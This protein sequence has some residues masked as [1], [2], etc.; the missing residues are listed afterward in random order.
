MPALRSISKPT[1]FA[2]WRQTSEL[3]DDQ[4]HVTETRVVDG[5]APGIRHAYGRCRNGFWFF[6]SMT[7]AEELEFWNI[8]L[9]WRTRHKSG[10]HQFIAVSSGKPPNCGTPNTPP[11]VTQIAPPLEDCSATCVCS[12]AA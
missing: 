6:I 3:F 10:I 5:P 2:K 12:D 1:E 4:L 9:A 11:C 7:A 8:Y